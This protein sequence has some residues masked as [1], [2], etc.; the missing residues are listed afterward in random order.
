MNSRSV[1]PCELTLSLSPGRFIV[2]SAM[3]TL[4]TLSDPTLQPLCQLPV[5]AT[6][7]VRSL[8]GGGDFC[9]RVREI[10]LGESA[11][12]TKVG[13]RGPFICRVNGNRLALNHDTARRIWVQPIAPVAAT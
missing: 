2:S 6:G 9:Q 13:G 5:G 3:S 12:V 10:G 4:A 8:E 11:V 1:S 7:F